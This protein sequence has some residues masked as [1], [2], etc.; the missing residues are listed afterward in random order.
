[1]NPSPLDREEFRLA[2]RALLDI[3][4]VSGIQLSCRRG[5]L[6]IT[7][8]NDPRDIVLEAGE[9]FF[10]TEHRRALVYAFEA[11]VVATRTVAPRAAFPT[12]AREFPHGRSAFV[13]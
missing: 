7:L 10:S 12:A 11:S 5:S 3:P 2:P 8:D 13:R 4:D 1:M 6:W 9:S